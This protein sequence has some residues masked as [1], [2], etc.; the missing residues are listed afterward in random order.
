MPKRKNVGQEIPGNQVKNQLDS[1]ALIACYN[2][3]MAK[4]EADKRFQALFFR[5]IQERAQ[6]M[7]VQK[8]ISAHLLFECDVDYKVHYRADSSRRYELCPEG[9]KRLN[10]AGVADAEIAF[11]MSTFH[12]E[13]ELSVILEAE[14]LEFFSK[15]LEAGIDS[16]RWGLKEQAHR[17]A[18]QKIDFLLSFVP[19]P[20]RLMIF[21]DLM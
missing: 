15:H 19:E 12:H 20:I 6:L 5:A 18:R 14:S 1:C 2:E 3:A 10:G 17:V 11:M 9:R 7:I 4:L 16:C 13:S 8:I 21:S